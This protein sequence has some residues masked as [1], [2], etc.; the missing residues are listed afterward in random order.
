MRLRAF[1]IGLVAVGALSPAFAVDCANPGTQAE[2]TAC[3]RDDYRK[4]D[5]RLNETYRQITER[6]KH[7]DDAD[8]SLKKTLAA[9]I[10]A[11]RAWIAFRDAECT[12]VGSRT[13]GGSI[14]AT[15]VASCLAGLTDKRADALKA[16]M[17]CPEGDL[18]CPV[19]AQ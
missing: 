15:I 1:V 9:L 12:F 14:N 8:G 11:Q 19:P 17:D 10:A 13:T 7:S 3:S 2:M 6:L 5:S 4:A 16:Y 18:S